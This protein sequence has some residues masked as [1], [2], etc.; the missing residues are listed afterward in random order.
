M[1]AGSVAMTKIESLE[2]EVEKLSPAELR[3][4]RRWF[5]EFDSELWDRELE[6]DV[7]SGRL[8]SLADAAIA[9]HKRGEGRDI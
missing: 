2:K 6:A 3:A 1:A 5:A 8:D 9:A 4:F 7:A